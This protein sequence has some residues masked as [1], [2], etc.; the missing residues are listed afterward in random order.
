MAERKGT[1]ASAA[2]DERATRQEKPML[3]RY[4]LQVDGQKLVCDSASSG[5]RWNGD[6]E[7]IS[8]SSGDRLRR[9][10]RRGESDLLTRAKLLR[11]DAGCPQPNGARSS[12]F[13]VECIAHALQD[14]LDK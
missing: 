6:H 1:I 10:Y 9:G 4:R 12:H 14:L 2:A 5:S 11:S 3:E 7:K 8:D 13:K